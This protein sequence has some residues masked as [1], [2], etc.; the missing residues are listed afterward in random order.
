MKEL[1]FR[2]VGI[3]AQQRTGM[4]QILSGLYCRSCVFV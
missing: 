3:F 4:M 2:L 1:S